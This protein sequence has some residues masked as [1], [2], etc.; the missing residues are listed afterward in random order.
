MNNP[1]RILTSL[2]IAALFCSSANANLVIIPTFDTSITSSPDSAAIQAGINAAVAEM[3]SSI[4]TPITVRIAFKN[5]NTG[6]G[7][8]NTSF[9]E[10]SYSQYRSDLA[11]NQTLSSKDSLALAHLP[12]GANNPV[13]GNAMVNLTL[14]LLRAIGETALGDNGGDVDSTVSLNLGDM[15]LSRTGPQNPAKWDL[16]QVALHEISEVLGAG[17]G[18][19]VLASD[20]PVVP[21]GSVGSLDLYRFSAN[22]VR[23]FTTSAAATSY[24]SIDGGATKLSSFNQDASGDYADWGGNPNPQLQDAAADAGA[25]L[26]LSA[27]ELTALDIVGYTLA[28]TAKPDFNGDGKPDYLLSK[29]STG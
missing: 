20:G 15:N 10:L 28:T 16:K 24:F 8:S 19:S 12:A 5:V 17:G 3:Q 11:T 9:V 18:G 13:N 23:S 7:V 1:H 27:N 14:P 25:Q 29:S 21:T 22:N 26:D 4:L 2:S 6:L